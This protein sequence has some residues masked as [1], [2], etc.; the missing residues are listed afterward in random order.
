MSDVTYLKIA[1]RVT[2]IHRAME[3]ANDRTLAEGDLAS[4]AFDSRY[5]SPALGMTSHKIHTGNSIAI[6]AFTHKAI[7]WD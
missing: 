5:P 3:W 1:K 6:A 4:L 7:I 2:A